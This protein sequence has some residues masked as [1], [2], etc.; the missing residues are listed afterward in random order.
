MKNL[1]L[2]F[3]VFI[4]LLIVSCNKDA[5]LTQFANVNHKVNFQE[6]AFNEEDLEKKEANMLVLESF[7]GIIDAYENKDITIGDLCT[8]DQKRLQEGIFISKVLEDIDF[9]DTKLKSTVD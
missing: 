6:I 5:D 7:E 8:L 9:N 3:Q 1:I 4:F 2:L